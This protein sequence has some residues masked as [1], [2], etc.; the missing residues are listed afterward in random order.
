MKRLLDSGGMLCY[1]SQE[2]PSRGDG[3]V[4]LPYSQHSKVKEAIEKGGPL[5]PFLLTFWRVIKHAQNT[6]LLCTVG[7]LRRRVM[8]AGDSDFVNGKQLS[9]VKDCTQTAFTLVEV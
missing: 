1:L 4:L 8:T 5:W 2:V 3:R 6:E 9:R 7:C